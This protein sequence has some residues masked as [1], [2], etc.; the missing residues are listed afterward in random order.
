MLLMYLRLQTIQCIVL[1][2][3]ALNRMLL[4]HV[5]NYNNLSEHATVN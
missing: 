2:G 3:D 1:E 4:K 5:A